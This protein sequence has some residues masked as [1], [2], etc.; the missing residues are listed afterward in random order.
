MLPLANNLGLEH[1]ET[2]VNG[3]GTDA[4][5]AVQRFSAGELQ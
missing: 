1:Q 5:H 3:L 4:Q 2:G